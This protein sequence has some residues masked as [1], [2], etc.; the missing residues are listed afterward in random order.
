VNG[1]QQITSP[2]PTVDNVS[3]N[4]IGRSN[5]PVSRFTGNNNQVP[6]RKPIQGNNN[7]S[8]P[9]RVVKIVQ[10]QIVYRYA[11]PPRRANFGVSYTSANS[12][13]RPVYRVNNAPAPIIQRTQQNRAIN[14]YNGPRP[15]NPVNNYQGNT[16][17]YP[18]YSSPPLRNIQYRT[19][20]RGGYMSAG[21]RRR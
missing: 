11:N 4:N 5:A 13:A 12:T 15:F 9:A 20:Q 6:F 16:I 3:N 10:P 8:Q 17:G 7:M 14:Y 2:T 18:R 1:G 21:G 19:M